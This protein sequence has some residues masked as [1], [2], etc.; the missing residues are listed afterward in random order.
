MNSIEYFNQLP[1]NQRNGI[2]KELHQILTI[3]IDDKFETHEGSE[4]WEI[5]L[6][7]LISVHR[8]RNIEMTKGGNK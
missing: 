4:L 8:K 5:V 2:A 3:M 1:V 7:G 6:E